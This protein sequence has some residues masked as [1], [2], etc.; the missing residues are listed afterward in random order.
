MG[1]AL[2]INPT[3]FCCHQINSKTKHMKT[4]K[5]ITLCLAASIIT[6][7][8]FA[9]NLTEKIQA[10]S[11]NASKGYFYD[12]T[13]DAETGNIDVVY[14][15]KGKKK[16]DKASYETYSFDKNINFLKQEET[17]VLKKD[18]ADKPDY[19][20]TFVYAYVGG[21]N[22]MINSTKLHLSK[23][24]YN[25]TWNKD[26]KGYISKRTEDIE[27]KPQNEEKR[28][29]SGYASYT[30]S[31]N[32]DLMVLATSVTKGDD[33]A[34]TKNFVVLH[35]KIDLSISEIPLKFASPQQLVY[36]CLK[37][38]DAASTDAEDESA[39]EG[40]IKSADM[41][42]IFAPTFNKKNPVDYKKYTYLRMDK[43]G[44][45]KEQ[46]TFDAPSPNFIITGTGETADG[47]LYFCGSYMDD[48]KTFDQ[49][50]KEYSPLENPYYLEGANSRMTVY[51]AKTEKVKM[52]FFSVMKVSG[53][54]VDWITNNS[55]KEMEKLI[56]TPPK[57]KK[58]PAYTGNRFK[59]Q[60]FVTMPN[61]D[62]LISGQ[63]LGRVKISSYNNWT[64]S[65]TSYSV[66]AYKD[67]VCMQLNAD[68]KVKA[69]FGVHPA[70][71]SDKMNTTFPI[72][73]NFYIGKDGQSIYWNLLETKVVKGYASF[74]DAYGGSPKLY[75]NYYP[76]MLK[77]NLSNS[78]ITE[79]N[80]FG[81]RKFLLNKS[82][83]YIY[84][85]ADKSIV[86][87]GS[88]KKN[89]LWL[90]KYVMN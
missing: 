60:N 43:T 28:T 23:Q 5:R 29:Y 25:Y 2:L 13:Q 48:D 79:Y 63:L 73:E 85:E 45:I 22:F 68:G 36:T 67:V 32:G 42:Y 44:A 7:A 49:L 61:G 59:V 19:S 34:A 24:T 90:V 77:M 65:V 87:I 66:K 82:T 55:I 14:K 80:V 76:S 52:D 86:Y 31:E 40:D 81:S 17:Q 47:A 6:S 58:A 21:N 12:A 71:V 1:I 16:D 37:G 20:S 62:I 33:E 89:K 53:G 56:Q 35:V 57:Q 41:V 83:P 38:S 15:F 30:N 18:I 50:Y 84:N 88:D 9:Q 70:S 26:K 46:F 51:E 4:T 72:L 3:Q 74:W 8:S 11:K 75:P 27:I 78:S 64:N 10:L 54:K 69:Q 39:F